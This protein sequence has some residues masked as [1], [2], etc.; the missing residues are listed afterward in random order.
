MKTLK[1]LLQ[2]DASKFIHIGLITLLYILSYTS[3]I[4]IILLV[5]EIIYIFKKSKNIIIYSLVLVVIITIRISLINNVDIV[6]SL[7]IT[8]EINEVFDN[9]FYL[10]GEEKYLCYYDEVA[11]L[12][13]G[14]IVDIDGYFSNVK[15]YNMMHTFDY[16]TYLKSENISKVI[17]IDKL[18]VKGNNF[19]IYIVKH[20]IIDYIDKT[21]NIK[22]ASYLKLFVL[23]E[24]VSNESIDREAIN[25]L[26]IS[27]LFAI[28]GMHLGLLVGCIAFLLKKLYISKEKNQVII[29]IFLVLY[30]IITGFKISIIRASLLV[31][32]IYLKDY[33]NILLTKTDLLTF[34]FVVLLMINPYS[35][36]SLGFQLSYLIAFSIVLGE[37]ILKKSDKITR[38][39][40]TTIFASLVSLPIT[41]E[42]NNTFGLIFIVANLFF[43]L[44]VS[45]LFL[46]LSIM[47]LI[48]PFIR[49]IYEMTIRV[50][51]L[52]LDTFTKFNPIINFNFPNNLYKCLF[53]V[54]LFLIITN[55][56]NIKR[57]IILVASMIIIVLG[58]LFVS[59]KSPRFVRFLDVFQGDSI[60]IHD[61]NCDMLIDTGSEDKYNNLESYFKGYNI[62]EID[63]ILITHFHEDHY[64]ELNDIVDNIDVGVV[65]LNNEVNDVHFDYQV[66]ETGFCFVCGES[67][68]QV[69]SA[70]T[71]SKNE[72]NNSLVLYAEIGKDRYLFTGDI[73]SEIESQIIN[74]YDFEV[75]IL[76]VPHHG[77]RTSSTYDFLNM[78]NSKIAIISVG[79]RNYYS[80]PNDD[81]L[82]RLKQ[83]DNQIYRTDVDGTITI[84]YYDFLNIRLIENYQ[85]HKR[86]RY[87]F[88]NI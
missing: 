33:L 25:N 3:Y 78:M 7:P 30:N 8:G 54:L 5:V 1:N 50:F 16:E 60:H 31:S 59:F 52:G 42:I 17:S 27:H 14:M 62:K 28:S 18:S 72:N 79:E 43:I 77:S 44:Y 48:L 26:G 4:A 69:I 21:Y 84:Y 23:G 38:L 70:N 20:K 40:K 12:E 11:D 6:E 41:L 57:Q 24:K 32:C 83:L 88:S 68:F 47:V 64:G 36:Y 71:N 80:L 22:T 87:I 76:K 10:K 51:E 9:S 55:I 34:S 67:K 45:Y 74:T 46:P 49:P 29:V 53:W 61:G 73:E 66:L 81:V 75:D 86:L 63:I 39:V 15:T 19:N 37:Y 58:S 13:P 65:Y 35:L 82:K 2:S 56:K 85:K